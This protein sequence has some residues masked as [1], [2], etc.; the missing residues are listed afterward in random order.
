MYRREFLRLLAIYFAS[1]AWQGCSGQLSN[2]LDTTDTQSPLH[3]MRIIDAH[4]HPDQ[5]YT[6]APRHYDGTS[7][8]KSIRAVGMLSLI[9][10]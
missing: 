1:S 7:T 8:L 10:I 6:P 4:A 5:F 9:H 3:G 2:V